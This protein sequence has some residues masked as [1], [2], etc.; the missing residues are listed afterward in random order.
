[1]TSV[2]HHGMTEEQIRAFRQRWGAGP[3]LAADLVVFSLRFQGDEP[4]PVV[5]LVERKRPPYAGYLACPGGFVDPHE[6]LEAAARRELA[7]ETGLT[8]LER[9]YVEQ[10]GAWG[11][12]DR[13]PRGRVVSVV[14]LAMGPWASLV[15]PQAGDDASHASFE[16]IRDGLPVD[17][18]GAVRDLAF[19]H[20]DVLRRAWQRVRD[21]TRNSSVSLRLL[22][23]TFTGAQLANV[24][25]LLSGEQTDE[26]ALVRCFARRCWIEPVGSTGLWQATSTQV[27]AAPAWW[28]E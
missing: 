11:K 3:H 21:L 4:E 12:P 26:P 9:A 10:L 23:D 15:L 7:E 18:T 27:R 25:H 16:R 22:P 28:R 19:D 5:L 14:Y 24:W 6:D 2:A 20:D 1:M 13:D 8:N 17:R